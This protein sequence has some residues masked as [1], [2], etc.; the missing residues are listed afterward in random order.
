MSEIDSV[1]QLIK[2]NQNYYNVKKY[3]FEI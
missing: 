1:E 2:Y 3:W